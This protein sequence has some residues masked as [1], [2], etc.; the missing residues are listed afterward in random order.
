MKKVLVISG[1]PDLASS[2]SNSLIIKELQAKIGNIEVRQLDKLYPDFK[3]DVAAE[4]KAMLAADIIVL[5]FPFHWYS[6]PALLK[7]WIDD[8]FTFN[9]AYGPEGDKL[10]KKHFQLSFTAGGPAQAYSPLGYNHFT[11]EQLIHPLQQLCYLAQMEYLPPI[12]SH[13]MVYI[14]DVYN[15]LEEVQARAKEH[16]ARLIE[17]LHAL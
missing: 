13:G 7:K 2:N 5:Q 3:I 4:Q 12:Y 17:K 16:A 6:V 11:I 10:A 8:V 15:K 1:H 9:F 14:P